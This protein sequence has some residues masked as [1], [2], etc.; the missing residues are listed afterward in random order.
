MDGMIIGDREK[1]AW[2]IRIHAKDHASQIGEKNLL[3]VGK[4]REMFAVYS[5]PSSWDLGLLGYL[6]WELYG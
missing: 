1:D 6:L 2:P 4:A 3:G 5:V